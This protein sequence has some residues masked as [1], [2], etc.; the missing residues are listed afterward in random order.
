M[1]VS[2]HEHAALLVE[3]GPPE[4]IERAYDE[5]GDADPL[6][7][8]ALKGPRFPRNPIDL[9]SFA[10]DR[11]GQRDF[12]VALQAIDR[13]L[14]TGYVQDDVVLVELARISTLRSL[15]RHAEATAAWSAT[16]EAWLSGARKVWR[17]QWVSLEELHKQLKLAE[18]PQL[19]AV[20]ERLKTAPQ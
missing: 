3:L 5:P 14:G 20:R 4:H 12:A 10:R 7:S 8:P 19:A 9:W 16:A 18:G 11:I 1:I 2:A 17:S 13:L 15:S 6:I